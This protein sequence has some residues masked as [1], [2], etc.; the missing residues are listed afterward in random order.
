MISELMYAGIIGTFFLQ[1]IVINSTRPFTVQS[2]SYAVSLVSD[3]FGSL[4]LNW[5]KYVA[6]LRNTLSLSSHSLTI[7]ALSC[8]MSISFEVVSNSS[9]VALNSSGF[10]SVD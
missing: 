7:G 9:I 3:S 4:P 5:L 8:N 2:T 1:Q 10:C 6:T